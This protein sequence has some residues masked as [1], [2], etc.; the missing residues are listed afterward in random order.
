[1]AVTAN[2]CICV[3]VSARRKHSIVQSAMGFRFI[4]FCSSIF[5]YI[6]FYASSPLLLNNSILIDIECIASHQIV[7]CCAVWR[8][9]TRFAHSK[10]INEG[11]TMISI[12]IPLMH[13]A[14]FFMRRILKNQ[15]PNAFGDDA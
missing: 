15:L 8:A 13:E 11:H 5:I 6:Q 3:V 10:S 7:F 9:R 1:M 12:V 4:Y 14:N 2:W